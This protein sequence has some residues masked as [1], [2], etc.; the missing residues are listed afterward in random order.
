[1]RRPVSLQARLL[2]VLLLI[3]P[4][5]WLAASAA[6]VW[7]AQ[8][9]VDELFDTQMA[10]FARQLLAIDVHDA[11]PDDTPKLKH[12]LHGADAGRM[13]NG[14]L[15]LAVWDRQ[16]NRL[17]CDG[18]GRRFDYQPSRRGFYDEPGKD[19]HHDWRM[20][21]LLSADGTRQVAV[22]Q[23]LGLRQEMVWSVVTAQLLPW[24]I[25]LP[26]MLLAILFALRRE[27]AP[28]RKLAAVIAA[29]APDDNS[30]VSADVPQEVQPLLRSLNALFGR[31]GQMLEHER[32]FTADAAHELRTPLAALRV[33]AEVLE[34]MPDDAGRRHALAQLQLGI[35]R[36]GRLVEQLLALSRLDPLQQPQQRARLDWQRL[37]EHMLAELSPLAEQVEWQLDWRCAP[38]AA[39][40]LFGDEAL[41]GLMLRNLLENACRYGPADGVVTVRLE[42]DAVSVLDQGPGIPP[43]WLARVRERFFRPPGQQQAGSGLGL[44][45][46]ERIAE[47]HGL[48]LVLRNRPEGGLE[49]RL[50]RTA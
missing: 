24:L 48:R 44:S 21:Y 16:G 34:L 36:A 9:E 33:Q 2:L 43:Q 45:I 50:E 26:L 40:P 6:A 14:D 35:A 8:R 22:G 29:R 32:R 46:V 31:M 41:L 28:L 10:Q 38:E 15:G 4:A 13:D 23:K 27:L 12:L 49:A 19:R 1:M 11:V 39:L 37:I 7:L 3:V 47:L 18:R 20:L 42:Q 17:L 30:P 5:T 25:G